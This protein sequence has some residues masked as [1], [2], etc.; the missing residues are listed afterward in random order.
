M[1]DSSTPRAHS[2]KRAGLD[3][4]PSD[5]AA[6]FNAVARRYDLTNEV[7]T[8]GQLH[9]WRRA[10]R[11]A[12]DP[13]PGERILDV[14]SGTGGSTAALAQ[15]G[16]QLVGCDLSE[17]MIDVGRRRHPQLEF[18]QADATDLPFPDASF[19][20]VTISFGLRNI[21][22]TE[23]ALREFSR[24]VAPGGRLVICEF[25]HPTWKPF[26]GAYHFYLERVLPTVASLFSSEHEAYD[27]LTES[28]L[29]W[30]DQMT[31]GQMIANNGWERVQYRNFTGGIVTI[32]R[33]RRP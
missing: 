16:A 7:L 18:V 1:E 33:A 8:L 31:L 14:A 12:L 29:A 2:S 3:K 27:Y 11:L 19:N 20:A 32:H 10:A 17:G 6:M 25:S 13:Q 22:N 5:I 28:I 24:V 21:E 30:P 9:V 4:K 23:K 26:A 15:S